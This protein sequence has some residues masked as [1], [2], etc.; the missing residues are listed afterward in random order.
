MSRF[1][2]VSGCK[3][4]LIRSDK[5]H[6]PLSPKKLETSK[7]SFIHTLVESA[8]RKQNKNILLKTLYVSILLITFRHKECNHR[9]V[10]TEVKNIVS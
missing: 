2:S 9:R 8:Y 6:I 4:C 5:T 3:K 10:E 1:V 7:S